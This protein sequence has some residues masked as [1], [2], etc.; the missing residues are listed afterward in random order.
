[1]VGI[2][3]VAAQTL[4]HEKHASKECISIRNFELKFDMLDYWPSTIAK[5]KKKKKMSKFRLSS[6]LRHTHDIVNLNQQGKNLLSVSL[7]VTIFSFLPFPSL[8]F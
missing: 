7:F 3:S 5:S 4:L 6:T 2:I 1:M 8:L